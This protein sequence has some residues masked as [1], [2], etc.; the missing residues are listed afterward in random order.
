MSKFIESIIHA[1]SIRPNIEIELTSSELLRITNQCI[2]HA[3][4]EREDNKL[5]VDV[6]TTERICLFL[7]HYIAHIQLM[8]SKLMFI[9]EQYD[10]YRKMWKSWNKQCELLDLSSR[11]KA[12]DYNQ[13]NPHYYLWI[14]PRNPKL[15]ISMYSR[16]I[17]IMS[18]MLKE[19][20]IKQ[21]RSSSYIVDRKY[22]QT[23]II[24]PI[25]NECFIHTIKHLDKLQ[26]SP[27]KK[28]DIASSIIN[29]CLGFLF[30]L[31]SIYLRPIEVDKQL[32][33][34]NAKEILVR[35]LKTQ[36][37]SSGTIIGG[38]NIE[39]SNLTNVKSYE[40]WKNLYINMAIHRI[41]EQPP[42]SH[43][44]ICFIPS[45]KHFEHHE[46]SFYTEI[47]TLLGQYISYSLDHQ[48]HIREFDVRKPIKHFET[49]NRTCIY[50][51][52]PNKPHLFDLTYYKRTPV[53]LFHIIPRWFKS[54]NVI[55]P[56]MEKE[57]EI[58][59]KRICI[60]GI[61]ICL[62]LFTIK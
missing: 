36:I 33:Y 14:Q 2:F 52:D 57:R 29:V 23:S 26:D 16:T 61:H 47:S 4:L 41:S 8:I 7:I 53:K 49:L 62:F 17:L 60:Q 43:L 34:P 45:R 55:D 39:I 21:I 25:V 37:S 30:N 56:Y 18:E 22:F 32:V 5:T 54:I 48:V 6:Q 28:F 38:G 24:E 50:Q 27:Q 3:F 10:S 35:I 44:Y 9:S 59:K 13:W 51:V 12:E 58:I 15:G 19:D 46:S 40:T 31:L 42:I 1:C 11:I 20:I